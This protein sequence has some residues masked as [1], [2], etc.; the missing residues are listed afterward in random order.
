MKTFYNYLLF[1]QK[2]YVYYKFNRLIIPFKTLKAVLI[3]IF[4]LLFIGSIFL[5]YQ[6]NTNILSDTSKTYLVLVLVFT[7]LS[8]GINTAL[9]SSNKKQ[10]VNNDL[11]FLLTKP[12]SPKLILLLKYFERIILIELFIAITVTIGIG[13]YLYSI[14][15][16]SLISIILSVNLIIGILLLKLIFFY[17]SFIKQTFVNFIIFCLSLIKNLFTV[18]LFLHFIFVESN[19]L[20]N[21]SISSTVQKYLLLVPI[22]KVTL[23]F[24]NQVFLYVIS[25]IIL[26]ITLI[27]IYSSEYIKRDIFLDNVKKKKKFTYKTNHFTNK[28]K[29]INIMKIIWLYMMRQKKQEIA[30]TYIPLISTIVSITIITIILMFQIPETIYEYSLI[31]YL[32]LTGYIVK[33]VIDTYCFLVCVDFYGERFFLFKLS[34][35]KYSEVIFSQIFLTS[36]FNIILII[37]IIP[38]FLLIV[39]IDFIYFIFILI[40]IIGQVILFNLIYYLSSVTYPKFKRQQVTLLPSTKAKIS[41]NILTF[42]SLGLEVV[43]YLLIKNIYFFFT[44]TILINLIY[45]LLVYKLIKLKLPYIRLNVFRVDERESEQVVKS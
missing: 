42:I 27:I 14:G 25:L 3:G 8:S 39:P 36:I 18:L 44:I 21:I 29:K 26:F 17:Y 1:R 45:S 10:K 43:L 38:F 37:F 33:M 35:I 31:F 19:A 24:E 4:I 9:V 7:F 2:S 6:L 30:I 22:Q 15:I 40:I 20:N 13:M 16:R 32:I 34:G 41:A 5:F 12:L 11:N 28:N 23:I